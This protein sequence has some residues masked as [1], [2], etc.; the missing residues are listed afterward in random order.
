MKMEVMQS[1]S[2][3]GIFPDVIKALR[4]LEGCQNL[5]DGGI[6]GMAKGTKSTAAP[7]AYVLQLWTRLE[8]GIRDYKVDPQRV[9]RIKEY[10]FREGPPWKDMSGI[11]NVHSTGRVATALVESG[12]KTD[13]PIISS[14]AKYMVGERN[15][16]N[17]WGYRKGEDSYPY[18]TYFAIMV[19]KLVNKAK[20][21]RYIDQGIEFIYKGLKSKRWHS[22]PFN[23]AFGTLLL[24]E[25]DPKKYSKVIRQNIEFLRKY[26]EKEPWEEDLYVNSGALFH[27]K[28]FIPRILHVFL[29]SAFHPLDR[30]VWRIIR[31]LKRNQLRDGGWRWGT[32][33][34]LS[35]ATAL[36]LISLVEVAE[37]IESLGLEGIFADA[38]MHLEEIRTSEVD[39]ED[40]QKKN[41]EVKQKER[42]ALFMGRLAALALIF[43]LVGFLVIHLS[44][45]AAHLAAFLQE[46][47]SQKAASWVSFILI[48]V[49]L[50]TPLP[51][52]LYYLAKGYFDRTTT[53][54]IGEDIIVF[55]L[56]SIVSVILFEL[57]G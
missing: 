6:S 22:S 33:Q 50:L 18:F 14:A 28:Y 9:Q 12:I 34:S 46:M 2:P 35:W 24:L 19:L 49:V 4:F 55:V 13:D 42:Q 20:Y 29:A 10:L 8:G 39:K 15:G 11:P 16:D 44:L 47:I 38:Y 21:S 48:S 23:V 41:K 43:C 52:L 25:T 31:W 26:I 7:T 57:V 51:Y 40:L 3:R 56:G 37:R 36:S 54:R 27:M 53:I 30:E 45:V 32:S 1:L 5:T 17:G